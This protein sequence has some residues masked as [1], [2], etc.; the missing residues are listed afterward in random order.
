MQMFEWVIRKDIGGRKEQQDNACVFTDGKIFLAAVADGLGGH[1]GGALASATVAEK[2][3]EK[4]SKEPFPVKSP[5][6]WLEKLCSQIHSAM[7]HKGVRQGSEPMTTIVFLLI[8]KNQA[9][10]FH[11][12]DSRLYFFSKT[13]KSIRTQDHSQVQHL[14]NIGLVKEED[15]GHHPEQNLLLRCLGGNNFQADFASEDFCKGTAIL[16]CTDGFWEVFNKQEMLRLVYA[17]NLKENATRAM[18]LA[19][20]RGGVRGDNLTFI[21]VRA[22]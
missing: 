17:K 16:L 21:V 7:V 18:N 20:K 22:L 11:V 4:F 12:G 8:Q 15:M 14:V 13:K 9:Y 2:V 10:W 3:K 1:R 5:A 6:I 19:V